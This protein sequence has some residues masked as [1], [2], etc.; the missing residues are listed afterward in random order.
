ML[1]IKVRDFNFINKKPINTGFIA[2]ELYEVYPDP[3]S[4]GSDNSVDEPLGIDY[5][6][7]TPLIIKSI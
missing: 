3:V 2:Q 7:L 5:G 4:R 1:K 6:K